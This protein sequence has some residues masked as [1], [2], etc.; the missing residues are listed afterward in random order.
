MITILYIKYIK[1]LLAENEW[2]STLQSGVLVGFFLFFVLAVFVVI[3][4]PKEYYKEIS[5]I[6]LENESVD[7]RIE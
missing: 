6:P 5:E 3:K 2:A 1:D 4:R 7:S